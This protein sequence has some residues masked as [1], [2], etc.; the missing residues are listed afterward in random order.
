MLGYCSDDPVTLNVE[1]TDPSNSFPSS[2]G[3]IG[4][5]GPS[6]IVAR[7]CSHVS[8]APVAIAKLPLCAATA[9]L[10]VAPM[11]RDGLPPT[12][13]KLINGLTV[14]GVIVNEG[15]DKNETLVS[16]PF[17]SLHD[18][19]ENRLVAVRLPVRIVA[20]V[21]R[22]IDDVVDDAVVMVVVGSVKSACMFGNALASDAGPV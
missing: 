2:S 14:K 9:Q 12:T 7:S 10:G 17:A 20:K 15:G 4:T 16:V 22:P 8:S 21:D 1:P 19:P 5:G 6:G 11:V 13:S 3:P 18:T